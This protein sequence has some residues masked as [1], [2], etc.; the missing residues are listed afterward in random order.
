[1]DASDEAACR[2]ARGRWAKGHSGNPAGKPRGRRN[3]ATVLREAL[4]AGGGDP[5]VLRA[6]VM[7]ALAGD[8]VAAR[9]VIERLCVD[10]QS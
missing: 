4:R 6:V 5:A 7:Q 9:L 3:R 10:R 1:M 8:A 2:A